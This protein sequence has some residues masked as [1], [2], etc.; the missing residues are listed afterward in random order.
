MGG[1]TAGSA[2]ISATYC[3]ANTKSKCDANRTTDVKANC[4]YGPALICSYSK[5]DDDS[6]AN[7]VVITYKE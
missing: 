7:A 5:E 1:S 2:W 6:I 4:T 3:A